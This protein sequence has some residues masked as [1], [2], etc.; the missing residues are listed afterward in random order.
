MMVEL[1]SQNP[2]LSDVDLLRL[3]LDGCQDGL[4]SP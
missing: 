1:L 2:E 4:G 3:L